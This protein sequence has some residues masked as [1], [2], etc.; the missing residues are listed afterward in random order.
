MVGL[1]SACAERF[2]STFLLRFFFDAI[3]KGTDRKRDRESERNGDRR[4]GNDKIGKRKAYTYPHAQIASNKHGINVSLPAN[5]FS[6]DTYNLKY[7]DLLQVQSFNEKFKLVKVS[8][9]KA[10][11]YLNTVI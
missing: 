1:C 8:T 2:F 6:F 9:Y 7:P 3:E 11:G 5:I 10:E 4:K